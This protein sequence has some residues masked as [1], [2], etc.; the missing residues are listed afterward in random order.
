VRKATKDFPEFLKDRISKEFRYFN[1]AERPTYNS[2]TIVSRTT[3]TV[4]QATEK[5]NE[6]NEKAAIDAERIISEAT[7]KAEKLISDTFTR[8][9]NFVELAKSNAERKAEMEAKIAAQSVKK[10]GEVLKTLESIDTSK[11]ELTPEMREMMLRML[12]MS[13]TV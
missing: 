3:L 11:V 6:M 13:A 8:A 2:E 5:A 7:A 10:A 4:E 9:N 1:G 12:G